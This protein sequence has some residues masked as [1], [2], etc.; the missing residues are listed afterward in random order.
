MIGLC[1][2]VRIKEKLCAE[3]RQR[4]VDILNKIVESILPLCIKEDGGDVEGVLNTDNV[5]LERVGG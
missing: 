5:I 1:Q 3:D 2:C 4:Y